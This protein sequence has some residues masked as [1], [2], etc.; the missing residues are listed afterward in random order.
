MK[1]QLAHRMVYL[2]HNRPK[3]A[4]IRSGSAIME[5]GYQLDGV[6]L[7]GCQWGGRIMKLTT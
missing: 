7:D 5:H 4:K 1:K 2:A 6:P 3:R